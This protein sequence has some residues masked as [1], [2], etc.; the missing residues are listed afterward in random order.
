MSYQHFVIIRFSI[1]VIDTHWK[2]PLENWNHARLNNIFF[3]FENICLPSLI[4]QHSKINFHV[5]ILISHDLPKEYKNKLNN[6]IK[7]YEFIKIELVK[8]KSFHESTVF[9]KKYL[10]KN[11]KIIATTRLDDDDALNPFF[12][13]Y[14]AEHIKQQKYDDYFVT[15][16]NGYYLNLNRKTKKLTY[17]NCKW[18]F[19]ACGLTRISVIKNINTMITVFCGNHNKIAKRK[20]N[21]I[22]D[23]REG[24]Y[25]VTNHSFNDSLGRLKKHSKNKN[26]EKL[27]NKYYKYFPFINEQKLIHGN[28]EK[29]I[30]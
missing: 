2:K 14:I 28:V 9:L 12:S 5:I 30:E 1:K 22:S 15:F 7:E 20:Y 11:T 6:L 3:L 10:L 23:R 24:M 8:D 26:N 17:L 25:S 18:K 21:Y 13:M 4:N 29:I 19:V 16:K 27:N